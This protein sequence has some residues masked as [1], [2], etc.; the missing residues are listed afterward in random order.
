M[1][2]ADAIVQLFAAIDLSAWRA[3]QP[4]TVWRPEPANELPRLLTYAAMG[5]EVDDECVLCAAFGRDDD[6]VAEQFDVSE[7]EG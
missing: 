5:A 3:S 4:R 7:G 2:P 1:K 6:G